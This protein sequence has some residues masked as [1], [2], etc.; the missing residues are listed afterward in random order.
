VDLVRI[1]ESTT[2]AGS[3]S[4]LP[5]MLA[6]INSLLQTG[7][8]SP[9]DR[10]IVDFV[11]EHEDKSESGVLS[12]ALAYGWIKQGEVPFDSTRRLL[13][14]LVSRDGV[15][16]DGMLITKGAVEEVLDRCVNV[17][18]HSQTTAPAML[19]PP[20]LTDLKLDASTSSPL[21]A[22]ESKLILETAERLNEDGLRLV[23][24]ACRN[25]LVKPFMTLSPADEEELTFIG[26]LGFLDPL[27]PDA[28]EAIENLAKL[29]VQV[30]LII[31]H[32]VVVFNG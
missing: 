28:A 25:T 9:I 5:I 16:G 30:H 20:S 4:L 17:Y 2:G 32:A 15:D 13:S 10:A 29:G 12:E 27:K 26:F 11:N 1:S 14:V 19:S 7:T 8:R 18:N 3:P 6:Y 24:V 23:A 31:I 21:T 22:D